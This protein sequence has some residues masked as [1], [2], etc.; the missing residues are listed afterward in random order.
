L[1]ARWRGA[2]R[3]VVARRVDTHAGAPLILPRWLYASALGVTGDGGLRDLV[4]RLP[5]GAVSLT[6]LASAEPDV[7]T[8]QDL[9]RARRRM[10]PSRPKPRRSAKP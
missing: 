9:E 10:R 5:R 7:D 1:I 3:K 8:P 2:R 4:R 6:V